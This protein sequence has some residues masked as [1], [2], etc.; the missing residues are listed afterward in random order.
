MDPIIEANSGESNCGLFSVARF[1]DPST[2]DW[3]GSGWQAYSACPSGGTWS[4]E[5]TEDGEIKADPTPGGTVSFSPFGVYQITACAAGGSRIREMQ[6][7]N[8][9]Q[10]RAWLERNLE[11]WVAAGL[12]VGFG[13]DA[14]G[15]QSSPDLTPG[16][17]S[18]PLRQ[19][20]KSLMQNR[21]RDGIFDRPVLHLPAFAA[22]YLCD[23]WDTITCVADVAFSAGY[24]VASPPVDGGG[25]A[26]ISGP[27]E[28]S[29]S[30]TADEILR[31]ADTG[32]LGNGLDVDSLTEMRRNY[33]DSIQERLAVFRYDPCGTYRIQFDCR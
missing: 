1:V 3:G 22:P 21:A 11:G 12:E 5:Q 2:V 20:L 16:T 6:A 24:G 28:Y 27:I 7:V 9:Q 8:E 10:S 13:A 29:V 17:G 23:C 14:P 33:D 30:P 18:I 25:W 4:C 31:T 32:A 15:L 26:Y 19:A